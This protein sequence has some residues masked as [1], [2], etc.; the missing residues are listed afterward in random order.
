MRDIVGRRNAVVLI[1]E[2][3]TIDNRLDSVRSDDAGGARQMMDAPPRPG[4]PSYRLR[5]WCGGPP[6]GQERLLAYQQGLHDA[7][8]MDDASLVEHC[9]VALEDGYQRRNA[10]WITRHA[11]QPSW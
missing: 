3:T 11:P 7:G 5:V 8:V 9:G 2:A 1:G 10:C 6:L 4:T